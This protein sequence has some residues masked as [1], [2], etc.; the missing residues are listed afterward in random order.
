MKEIVAVRSNGAS[1]SCIVRGDVPPQEVGWYA[2]SDAVST[3]TTITMT[4]KDNDTI[5]VSII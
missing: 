4:T 5:S 2:G 3:E 1:L